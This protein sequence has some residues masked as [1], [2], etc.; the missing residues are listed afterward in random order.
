MVFFFILK[1]LI[2]WTFYQCLVSGNASDCLLL[3]V[4]QLS[5]WWLFLPP[6]S[7]RLSGRFRDGIGL[8]LFRCRLLLDVIFFYR[9]VFFCVW[10]ERMIELGFFFR[11]FLI[12][13]WWSSRIEITYSPC[14]GL[15]HHTRHWT[16]YA[17]H[18]LN[19]FC[20]GVFGFC[21]T[22][23]LLA[24]KATPYLVTLTW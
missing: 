17:Y 11:L 8:W 7:C 12:L 18:Y 24:F 19:F 4:L 20:F 13:G 22:Y 10:M 2:S 15:I 1:N 6:I 14:N 5:P 23:L 3:F 9:Q 21:F 16:E